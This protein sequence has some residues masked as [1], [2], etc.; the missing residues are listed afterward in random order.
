[1][2]DYKN[3]LNLPQT[4]FPMRANLAQREPK[5]LEKWSEMQLYQRLQDEGA[6]RPTFTLHD[7]PPYANGKIHVGHALNKTLKDI[8]LKSKTLSGYRTPYVPGWDCHGL[9]IEL[10]VEKK[11]GKSGIN[12]PAKDFRAA[13]RKYAQS[14]IDIQSEAFQRLGIFG[15]W[16]N[17]YRT[18]DFAFEA[19]IVRTLQGIINNGYL[20]RGYKPVHW[21]V[22]C[23]SALAEAEVEYED[24]KSPAIYVRFN[25]LDE[26]AF[27]DRCDHVPDKHIHGAL[28]VVIWT[29]T[30]WSLPANQAVALHPK[31]EYVVVEYQTSS[32]N[33]YLF[34]AQE[35]LNDTMGALEISDYQV[36]AYCAG[37]AVEGLLLQHPF[38]DRQVP[39]VLGDHVTTE[40]GT[41][42]VHIAPG[43]GMDDY[44]VGLKYKLPVDHAVKPNG[45]FT[46]EV[47][48]VGGK[49]VTKAND[50]L[51]EALK[52]RG[53]L[54][55][56][57]ALKHSYPHCW[58]HKTPL[59]FRGT[60]QWFI[61]MTQN[62]LR[63][64]AQ[65]AIKNIGWI[66]E[67]GEARMSTMLDNRP[68]WCI[69]RQRS[70]GVPIPVF[71][72]KNTDQL[73]PDTEALM[74]KV[75]DLIVQEGIEAWHE[76]DIKEMLGA[77]AEHYSKSTDVLDV[78]FDSGSTFA[79]V[80]Q[81]RP[82][83]TFPADIYIEG[84][85]QYR[86]WFQ[87][88]LLN[89]IAK[90]GEAPYKQV[91]THGFTV[92]EKGRK[93]SKSLGNVVEPDKV[94]N[95]LGA[96]ILRLW[97]ASADYR[98][99]M[100]LSNEILK[101]STDVYRR[102]RNTARYFLSNLAGFDPATHLLPQSRMLALDQ[103][104]VAKTAQVQAEV[105]MAFDEYHFHIAAQKIHHFCAV[106]MGSFYLDIIKDRQYTTQSDSIARRSAQSA[107]YHIGEALCRW[108]APILA[109]TAE[110]IS[111]FM[112]GQ[113]PD[114][115]FLTT[116][117]SGL[118]EELS[119]EFDREYW[120]RII[121]MREQVNKA[122]EEAR[123]ENVIG[124]G[125]EAEITLYC[126]GQEHKDLTLL[127]DELRFVLI[128][129]KADVV[130]EENAAIRV[131]V[132]ASGHA[133]CARCWHR[134]EDIGNNVE[135]PELCQRCVDNVAGAGEERAIA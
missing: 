53:N 88:S 66:P 115:I 15:D 39:L 58:R 93:M 26:E 78:W 62:G 50:I 119:G 71:I 111:G 118:S 77:D 3:T 4:D 116:W 106:D 41:G 32:H 34:I 105:I 82:E 84:S 101:R 74:A 12:V 103:W 38:L 79:C 83:L 122:L 17:P 36:K 72:H 59:I 121:A 129:S 54:L 132:S 13:C 43:H 89:A 29:T 31:M 92:D 95:S 6:D 135:H 94:I 133:K 55:H 9:P 86:G 2:T 70:W 127:S 76:L 81:A 49:H 73:H 120:N 27:W 5:L 47:P 44:L 96:D 8:I 87:S 16:G 42:A 107:M 85:D 98:G 68:D 10:N 30:P 109:F 52:V 104:A 64:K 48:L 20:H 130:S 21:C 90:T 80:V 7:G 46:D 117:Y 24:K 56:M 40:T 11:L 14:Q 23:G 69:S 124:S 60:P 63:D 125:L 22:D 19:D 128:T 57:Q 134:R 113:R 110:E 131:E 123:T 97:A 1:M 37:S 100:S 126:S 61:S 18:M 99:E 112:P 28:S 25:V 102:I 67:W 114:S 45:C 65:A 33:E 75:A 91:I 35:L 51:I 108:L